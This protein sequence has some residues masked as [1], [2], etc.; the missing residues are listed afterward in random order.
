MNGGRTIQEFTAEQ[1]RDYLAAGL[2]DVEEVFSR[3]LVY[4]Q[5]VQERLRA[6]AN[7]DERVVRLQAEHR[8]AER[9]RGEPLGRLYGVPVAVED[10]IDTIDFPTA[11]GSPIHDG[12]YPIADAT[13]VR[14]LRE[15]GTVIF[16]K[17]VATEFGTVGMSP[18]LNPHNPSHASGGSA[19]GAAAAVAAGVVPMALGAARDGA[20]LLAASCCGVY[21]YQPSA[22]LLPRTGALEISPSLDRL[23]LLARCV[24]DLALAA[25]ITS[26]D[27]GH[28]RAT[29]AMPPRQL[30]SVCKS[31]PP[32]EPKFCFVRMPWW[33]QLDAEAREAC[34]AFVE[35]MQ[36]VVVTA[37]LPAVLEQ[38]LQWHRQ[39][40]EAELAFSLQREYRNSPAQLDAALR[41]RIEQGMRL[42]A[43]DYLLARDRIVHVAG[44][45]DEFF[46]RYDALLMPAA[47]GAA[48]ALSAAPIDNSMQAVWSFAGLPSV[49]MPLLTLGG[50]MP[51][52]IQAVGALHNDGRLLRAVRWLVNEFVKRGSS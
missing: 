30:G 24:E 50:G 6:F 48:P 41:E 36:G 44:A 14:R 38:A 52:G 1:F 43:L 33:P 46:E 20:V 31:E 40:E 17:T 29:H 51:F 8:K 10:V 2:A 42:P 34:D 32:V 9:A 26:G 11:L 37:E 12:R 19:G 5:Q 7:L 22:G 23:G 28:D 25:E 49:S 47:P 3:Q 18:A 13:A 4:A 15:A 21:G 16:G 35:L 27:D 45:F 39:V